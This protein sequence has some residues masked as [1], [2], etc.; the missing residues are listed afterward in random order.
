MISVAQ[1]LYAKNGALVSIETLRG[2]WAEMSDDWRAYTGG[3]CLGYSFKL[4]EILARFGVTL[5]DDAEFARLI[6]RHYG[7]AN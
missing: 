3:W 4:D 7:Q 1:V 2:S 5:D 6:E